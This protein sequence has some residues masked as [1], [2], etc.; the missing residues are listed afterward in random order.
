MKKLIG[1]LVGCLMVF[2]VVGSASAVTYYE[3]YE[4]GQYISQ[5]SRNYWFEFDIDQAHNGS[6]NSSLAF[7]NDASGFDYLNAEQLGSVQIAI[8][9]FSSDS[10]PELFDM[11]VDIYWSDADFIET[12]TFNANSNDGTNFYYTYDFTQTQIDGWENGGWGSIT[13][14]A[15]DIEGRHNFNDIR[16]DRVAIT[17]ANL[18]PVPESATMMLFGLGLLG[19]AVVSKKKQ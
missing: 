13:I 14:D 4:G 6:T 9:L 11:D 16:I 17:A 7:T 10:E 8:D 18:I 2:G 19:L 1:L 5:R 12:V 3:A 15:Y